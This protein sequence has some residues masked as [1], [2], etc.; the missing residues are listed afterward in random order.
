[1]GIAS[2][3]RPN[4]RRAG[5]GPPTGLLE[6]AHGAVLSGSGPSCLFLAEGQAHAWQVSGALK[7][8]GLGPVSYAPGP[9]AGAR[10]VG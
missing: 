9:V 2:G 5:A 4:Q 7:Y 1:M 6:S 8:Y 3:M 10:I